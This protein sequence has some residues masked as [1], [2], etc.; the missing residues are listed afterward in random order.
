MH[1]RFLD[2]TKTPY[3]YIHTPLCETLEPRNPAFFAA[4][5]HCKTPPYVS[6]SALYADAHTPTRTAINR[7]QK[8][9]H[10]TGEKPK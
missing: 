6:S 7:Q 8:L 9:E 3:I 2:Q 4:S 1:A 5:P 10:P